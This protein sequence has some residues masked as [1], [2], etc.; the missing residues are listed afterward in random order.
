ML[1]PAQGLAYLRVPKAANSSIRTRLA[2]SYNLPMPEG[3]VPN[4]DRFWAEQDPSLVRSMT[5]AEFQALPER[6]RIWAFSFVRHPAMRLYS[7]WN[8]KLVENGGSL[9]RAFVAMGV[10]RGMD[11]HA[12]AECVAAHED[13]D[14]DLHVRSQVSVLVHDGIVVPDFVGK[15]ETTQRDWAHVRYE[16]RMRFGADIGALPSKNMRLEVG[17]KPADVM[18]AATHKVIRERYA[19]DYARFYPRS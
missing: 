13:A 17:L 15:V 4:K 2:A 18:S 10:E 11:F 3:I 7:C 19:E 8:N 9:S 14:C 12:F 6:P 1:L 16:S 5:L